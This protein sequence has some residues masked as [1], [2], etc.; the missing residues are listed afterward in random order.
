M[1]NKYQSEQLMVLH[2]TGRALYEIG[3]I[4]AAEMQEYDK[5]C[6]VPVKKPAR[7]RKTISRPTGS[8]DTTSP[9]PDLM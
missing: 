2:E 1:K 6:L 7:S 4:T 8:I 9:H 3:A 5:D